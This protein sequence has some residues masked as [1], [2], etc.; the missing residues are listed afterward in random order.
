MASVSGE[1]KGKLDLSKS[2]ED[3]CG[4]TEKHGIVDTG[5]TDAVEATADS[6]EATKENKTTT[7]YGSITSVRGSIY[8]EGA[9]VETRLDT[10]TI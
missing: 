9:S 4:S 2:H 1:P 3:T 10:N 8:A 5:N 7:F 6:T